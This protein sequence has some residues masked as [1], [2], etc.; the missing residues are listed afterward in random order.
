[1]P[2]IVYFINLILIKDFLNYLSNI[3]LTKINLIAK[4]N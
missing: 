1:M 4:F 2:F 3:F